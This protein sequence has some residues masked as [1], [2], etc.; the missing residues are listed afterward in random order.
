MHKIFKQ[1][2]GLW[3]GGHELRRDNLLILTSEDGSQCVLYISD[4]GYMNVSSGCTSSNFRIAETKISDMSDLKSVLI[5]DSSHRTIVWYEALYT[6]R[7]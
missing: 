5:K 6:R 7:Y 1:V 2:I 3:A 4:D